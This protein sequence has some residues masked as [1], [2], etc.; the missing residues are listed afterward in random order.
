MMKGKAALK[1]L[2]TGDAL[3]RRLRP[4]TRRMVLLALNLSI[5]LVIVALY[6]L[7]GRPLY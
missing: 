4:A 7:R 1:A 3:Q 6:L 5:G 2:L